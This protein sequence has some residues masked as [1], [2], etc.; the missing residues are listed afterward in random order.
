MTLPKVSATTTIEG[1]VRQY[2]D[3]WNRADL[4]AML[5]F[6][7]DDTTCHLHGG[8]SHQ[9]YSA[10]RAAFA[11]QLKIFDHLNLRLTTLHLGENHVVFESRFTAT[12]A[13]RSEPF[14]FDMMDLLTLRAQRIVSKDTYASPELFRQ[15]KSV[16][17]AEPGVW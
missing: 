8:G 14:T 17:A 4:D 13:Q 7:T 2:A 9:G 10:V 11:H 6:H 12:L 3:A 16:H 5:A 1:L 15:L